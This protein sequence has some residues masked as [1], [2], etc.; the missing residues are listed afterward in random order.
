MKNAK[1]LLL[2]ALTALV[3]LAALSIPVASFADTT[4]IVFTIGVNSYTVNG[5]EM[6]MSMAPVIIGSRTYLPIRY[7]AEPLG[8]TVA[9]DE[10]DQKITITMGATEIIMWL[11][12]PIVVIDGALSQL[13]PD[14]NVTPML[15]EGRTVVPVRFVGTALGCEV[16]W[17]EALQQVI[18]TKDT[19][20]GKKPVVTEPTAGAPKIM[21][22]NGDFYTYNYTTSYTY[23]VP[24]GLTGTQP[25]KVNI[26]VT[27]STYLPDGIFRVI[28]GKN[29]YVVLDCNA[30]LGV[31]VVTL[32]ATNI[33][34]S[35]TVQFTVKIIDG[36]TAPPTVKFIKN[37]YSYDENGMLAFASSEFAGQFSKNGAPFNMTYG[38]HVRL[39]LMVTSDAG[40][41]CND[42][43]TDLYGNQILIGPS[44]QP[45]RYVLNL[46]AS[47]SLGVDYTSCVV[48]MVGENYPGA[49]TNYEV[50]DKP[51]NSDG[52]A[53]KPDGSG[54]T[55]SIGNIDKAGI[56]DKAGELSKADESSLITG[57]DAKIF[58]KAKLLRKP[59]LMVPV[60]EI[61]IPPRPK[62]NVVLDYS[63]T[64]ANPTDVTITAKSVTGALEPGITLDAD[65]RT[66]LIGP[67]V[68]PG[69][70]YVELSVSNESGTASDALTV[71]IE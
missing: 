12:N 49:F 9:F 30:E 44:V 55:G 2:A 64:G 18:I 28:T 63:V 62:Q 57:I 6:P 48:Y 47:N 5:V 69:A 43:E 27:S 29:N 32:K 45:G 21:L 59:A 50:P 17:N 38:E 1:T 15:V 66:L 14:P 24:F 54:S 20:G 37:A 23:K 40:Q 70:Y 41:P 51:G 35:D 53:G 68:K 65:G 7:V 42:F 16:T 39:T 71:I 3:L 19:G 61:K 8:A 13:D 36:A 26:N 22:K 31:Y 4:T 11:D 33:Y 46:T 10:S 58:D 60:R 67:D 52:N 25:M 34:G 56:A